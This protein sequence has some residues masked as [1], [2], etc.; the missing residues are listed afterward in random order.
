MAVKIKVDRDELR[1]GDKVYK[2]GDE[3]EVPEF[4]AKVIVKDLKAGVP[5]RT[6]RKEEKR[7]E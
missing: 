6:R 2:R 3:L 4:W 1:F 5:V 7:E